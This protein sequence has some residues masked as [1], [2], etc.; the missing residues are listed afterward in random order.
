[1]ARS[2]SPVSVLLTMLL[3][4]ALVGVLARFVYGAYV[5]YQA[6]E[7]LRSIPPTALL[8]DV[9]QLHWFALYGAGAG[10]V[11]GVVLVL[12]DWLRHG[13]GEDAL[14]WQTREVVKPF[15]EDGVKARRMAVGERFL[16]EGGLEVNRDE[17]K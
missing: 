14:G 7:S 4:G 12:I 9:M 3:V 1:M 13:N 10:A 6:G 8:M 15:A 2:K 16:E 11:F 17:S 5:I